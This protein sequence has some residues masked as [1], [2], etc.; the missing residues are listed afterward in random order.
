MTE[1]VNPPTDNV[2]NDAALPDAD[3]EQNDEADDPKTDESPE[4]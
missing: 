1:D 4:E 2:E 3:V